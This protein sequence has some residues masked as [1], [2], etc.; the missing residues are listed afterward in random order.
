MSVTELFT[1]RGVITASW[2]R[3]S[4]FLEDAQGSTSPHPLYLLPN[5]TPQSGPNPG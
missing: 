5:V 3:I 4:F 2:L 1:F